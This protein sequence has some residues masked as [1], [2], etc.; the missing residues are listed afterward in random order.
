[1][2]VEQGAATIV[3]KNRDRRRI[4]DFDSITVQTNRAPAEG[5][6]VD[7]ASAKQPSEF[8][9]EFDSTARGSLARSLLRLEDQ[10]SRRVFPLAEVEKITLESY[11][12]ERPWLILAAA[13]VGALAGGLL[14]AAVGPCNDEGSCMEKAAAAVVG[15]P[16]GFG[17]GLA[18]GF[19]LTRGLGTTDR[20][21]VSPKVSD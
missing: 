18:V 5:A 2:T 7:P 12:P 21:P 8:E 16:I 13:G 14:G 17:I 6:A 4:A 15:M 20:A 9:F 1:M 3:Y 11:S 19:P 10:R